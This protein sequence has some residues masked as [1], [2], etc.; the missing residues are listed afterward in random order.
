MEQGMVD[1]YLEASVCSGRPMRDSRKREGQMRIF[2]FILVEERVE[3]RLPLMPIPL[4]A[5][6]VSLIWF[7]V[8]VYLGMPANTPIFHGGPFIFGDGLAMALGIGGVL[9]ITRMIIGTVRSFIHWMK[10]LFS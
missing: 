7:W 5:L 4:A 9:F 3:E 2:R 8:R 6:I 10:S 1:G